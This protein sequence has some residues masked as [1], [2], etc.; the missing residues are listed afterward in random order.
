VAHDRQ[1]LSDLDRIGVSRLT[2]LDDRMPEQPAHDDGAE[3]CEQAGGA[4]DP[5][6]HLANAHRLVRHYG[7]RLLFVENIG[8]HIWAP[9]W[10]HDELGAA[11]IT[12]GLGKIVAQEAAALAPW[13]AAAPDIKE[14]EKRESA[15]NRRFKWAGSSESSQNVASSLQMARPLLS[16]KADELDAA[17]DLLGLPGGVLD[18]STGD[19]REHR[20]TDRLTRIAGCDYSPSATCPTWQ[21]FMSE[22]M[23][24]DVELLDFLQR[25]CGYALSGRRGEHLLPIFYGS[26]ANGKSTML[27][28]LQRMLGEYGGTAAPGLL[29]ARGGN[30]HPTGL[31]DL[32]GRRL[33]VASETGEA[34]RLNEELVK[35]LTGGDRITARRMRQDFYEFDPSHLLV[36]QTNHKPRVTG[37]DEGIWRRLRLVPFAVTVPADRRDV[38]LPEKLEAELPG[39]LTWAVEGWRRYQA[40]GFR[41]PA[42]VV[43]ATSE[44]RDASDQIGAFVAESCEVGTHYTASAGDLYRAYSIWCDEAGERPRTQREFGMRLSERGFEASKGTG[45][46]RR[47]RGLSVVGGD[48]PRGASG[49]S[50]PA[51]GLNALRTLSHSK[52]TESPATCATPATA[53]EVAADAYRSA[54]R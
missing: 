53:E 18:L 28:T 39:I 1:R 46:L 9:P 38:R 27:G 43:A 24:G 41:T 8:W 45:G 51:F 21:R 23:G 11:R 7:N 32:Q 3:L 44:Y 31:A 29:I 5:C 54:K 34:G 13:V 20:Q 48:A 17:A 26:G 10:R 22:I 25:L 16:C 12:Q 6:S 40:E 42:A 36:M 14:R 33:V 50:G 47:W 52:Q 15:M 37:S 30:E 2:D 35:A 4:H 19:H 49:V